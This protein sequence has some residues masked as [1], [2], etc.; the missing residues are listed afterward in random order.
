MEGETEE[1]GEMKGWRE[2]W[3]APV[4]RAADEN[5]GKKQEEEMSARGE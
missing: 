2:G 3:E 5:R 4:N 1:G